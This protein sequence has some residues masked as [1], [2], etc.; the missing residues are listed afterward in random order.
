MSTY[1]RRYP[2]CRTV[3]GAYSIDIVVV[4]YGSSDLCQ[5]IHNW[6]FNIRMTKTQGV[7]NLMNGSVDK[8]LTCYYSKWPPTVN[9]A[10]LGEDFRIVKMNFPPICGISLWQI[11]M[12]NDSTRA[13]ERS[14]ARP[15]I[16]DS[17]MPICSKAKVETKKKKEKNALKEAI[18][19]QR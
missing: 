5:R 15:F 19:D 2:P 3:Q 6:T 7:T 9:A 4:Q 18:I 14:A 11:R 16:W 10:H 8:A 13:I 17:T 12:R 1:H